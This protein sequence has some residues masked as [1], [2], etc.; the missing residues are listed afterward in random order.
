MSIIIAINNSAIISCTNNIATIIIARPW[1]YG[2]VGPAATLQQAQGPGARRA[3]WSGVLLLKII[4]INIIVNIYIVNYNIYIY[5]YND[6]YCGNM[7]ILYT[8]VNI[9]VINF[10][11]I[12][13]SGHIIIKYSSND[14]HYFNK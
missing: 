4:V 7:I 14:N 5:N 8:I 9:I 2:P 12:N 1:P 6:N 13:M 3:L 11:C 10:S